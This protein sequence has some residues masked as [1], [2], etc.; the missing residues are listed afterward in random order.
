MYQNANHAMR[1]FLD[2]RRKINPFEKPYL[3]MLPLRTCHI[4]RIDNE[5]PLILIKNKHFA[6]IR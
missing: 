4:Q 6:S 1:L 2:H 3:F 5:T